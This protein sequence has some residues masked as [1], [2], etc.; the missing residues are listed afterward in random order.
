MSIII[1]QNEF[2]KVTGIDISNNEYY[3]TVTLNNK[4]MTEYIIN[5]NRNNNLLEKK[6]IEICSKN[7]LEITEE[8]SESLPIIIKIKYLKSNMLDDANIISYNET[9][10]N[11]KYEK[12][13]IY[14]TDCEENIKIENDKIT[15]DLKKIKSKINPLHVDLKI[16]WIVVK[17]INGEIK[18]LTTNGLTFAYKKIEMIKNENIVI[19]VSNKTKNKNTTL[20]DAVFESKNPMF[21]KINE[22][23][24]CEIIAMQMNSMIGINKNI[25]SEY[26][27]EKIDNLIKKMIIWYVNNLQYK[28]IN[29]KIMAIMIA[30]KRKLYKIKYNNGIEEILSTMPNNIIENIIRITK[31]KDKIE[32]EKLTNKCKNKK[33]TNAMKY[34]IEN[35]GKLPEK[36]LISFEEKWEILKVMWNHMYIS[37]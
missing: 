23:Y 13:K 28:K 8:T 19:I 21:E 29:R 25:N 12:V 9:I 33:S 4:K 15:F 36:T 3:N 22:T 37:W 2:I 32:I 20:T 31:E 35:N 7:N 14:V 1:I 34:A 18:I 11:I 5:K 26:N 10:D 27:K 6:I 16:E 30:K 24:V 17:K